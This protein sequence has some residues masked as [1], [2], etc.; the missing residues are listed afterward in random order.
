MPESQ[1]AESVL[2]GL[3]Q[4]CLVM[5]S[6]LVQVVVWGL[7]HSYGTQLA[8]LK[9]DTGHAASTL[10]LVGSI[11]DFV[12]ATGTAPAGFLVH[13]MGFVRMAAVGTALLL[14]GMLADSFA[15]SIYFR[16]ITC[17]LVGVAMAMIFIPA[18]AVL[19]GQ[20]HLSPSFL[21]VAVGLASSGGGLGTVV[22]NLGFNLLLDSFSWRGA[23]RMCCGAFG[24]VL[25][26]SIVALRRGLRHQHKKTG[27]PIT[28]NQ[29]L[30]PRLLTAFLRVPVL[31]AQ[32]RYAFS[33]VYGC[34]SGGR[35]V[36]LSLVINEL[37]DAQRV[38]HLYGLVS[39]PIAVGMLLGPALVGRVYDLSGH[40]AVAFFAVG[41][42]VLLAVEFV[43]RDGSKPQGHGRTPSHSHHSSQLKPTRKPMAPAEYLIAVT[44]EEGESRNLGNSLTFFT[45]HG[46]VLSAAGK[47]AEKDSNRADMAARPPPI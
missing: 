10:A 36:L 15:P 29:E 16:F 11:R 22:V 3:Q 46:N 33:A 6:F 23:L 39:I 35:I 5:A 40:Y 41:G 19:Y 45:S 34:C 31:S 26:V 44:Q 24:L 30:C 47:K 2:P 32:C 20:G 1:S 9:A 43:F 27:K 17:S 13:R 7:F 28:G 25:L 14:F 4:A 38:A 8:A 18:V 42:I 21:P 37:F 12:F